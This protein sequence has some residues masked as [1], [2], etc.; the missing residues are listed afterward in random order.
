MKSFLLKQNHPNIKFSLL[1]N[2][3]FFEGVLPTGYSLAI[4]PSDNY[5]V[6][7]VDVKN[8]KN[9]FDFIP[10]DIKEE[11]DGSFNYKTSSGGSH[12]WLLYTGN[13]TLKNCATKFGLDLRIGAKGNNAGGYVKYHHNVDI[14]ECI[15]LIKPTLENLNEWL[16]KLFSNINN[17]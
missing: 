10:L 2:N 1:P 3:T 12:Y 8:N 7:D 9:G 14:R 5:I 15:D 13:K 16:E 11:L 6:L 17:E 4:C